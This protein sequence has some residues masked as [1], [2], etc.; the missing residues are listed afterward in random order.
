MKPHSKKLHKISG[1]N[2]TFFQINCLSLYMCLR[3][4]LMSTVSHY[5]HLV[6]KQSI[7]TQPLRLDISHGNSSYLISCAL[8]L[9][10]QTPSHHR[11]NSNSPIK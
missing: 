2:F 4:Y 6:D 11:V 9:S 5:C 10:L 1:I 8:L 3:S 7:Y